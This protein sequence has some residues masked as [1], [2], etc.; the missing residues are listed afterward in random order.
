MTT[1]ERKKYHLISAIIS[2]TD[3]DRV[4]EI[5]RM[6]NPEPYSLSDEEMRAS[7]IQRKRNFDT[8]KIMA[9]PHEQIKRRL[10]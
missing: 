1:L 5:E 6:Y 7:V 4:F 10:V 9:I 3:E 2:D 8:G